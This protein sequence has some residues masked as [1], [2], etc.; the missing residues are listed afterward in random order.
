MDALSNSVDLNHRS[1]VNLIFKIT[2]QFK[3]FTVHLETKEPHIY[4]NYHDSFYLK[5]EMALHKKAPLKI[6]F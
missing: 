1:T 3:F 5:L 6:C 4:H 2:L